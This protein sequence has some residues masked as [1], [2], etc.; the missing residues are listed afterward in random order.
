MLQ[1]PKNLPGLT[2]LYENVEQ[3]SAE[4]DPCQRRLISFVGQ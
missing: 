2:I 3:S 4:G 1:K